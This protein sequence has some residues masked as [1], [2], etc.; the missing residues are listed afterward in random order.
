MGR[1]EHYDDLKH[2]VEHGVQEYGRQVRPRLKLIHTEATAES[3]TG[4][5]LYFVDMLQAQGVEVGGVFVDYMQLLTS[6]SKSY[7]RHDELKDVCKALKTCAAR[8]EIPVIVAAQ[9]NR[10]ALADGIDAATMANIGE[11]ADI[12]RIAHDIYFVWQVDKTKKDNYFTYKKA[13][14]DDDEKQ[15]WDVTRAGDRAR[16][17]FYRPDELV[18]TTRELKT[19]YLYVE[20]WKARDGRAG[21]WGL[22]PYD[23][24]RGFIGENDK[25]KMAE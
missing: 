22:L 2:Q 13:K 24:E 3:I 1:S 11:G 5:L 8:L 14:T 17:I 19:G 6:D 25:K 23:G 15:I 10:Q 18:P 7:S 9:L 16:R 21:G 12:E 20:Q 4:N